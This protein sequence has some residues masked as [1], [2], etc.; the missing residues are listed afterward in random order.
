V[1][2]RQIPLHLLN[3]KFIRDIN[4]LY[5]EYQAGADTDADAPLST[6]S[7]FDADPGFAVKKGGG[8]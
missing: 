2:P 8:L 7:A 1:C 3:R 6:W 5:G 4:L